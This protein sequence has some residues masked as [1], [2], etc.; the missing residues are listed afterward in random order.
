[1]RMKK[2]YVEPSILVEDFCLN[3]NIAACD[4]KITPEELEWMP[5][6]ND[7]DNCDNV[8]SYLAIDA[9]LGTLIS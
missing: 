9:W 8:C 6:Y 7:F 3:E 4:I 2:A 1:M 5:N